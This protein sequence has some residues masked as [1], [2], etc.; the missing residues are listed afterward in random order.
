MFP[1]GAVLPLWSCAFRFGTTVV[2]ATTK[3]AVPVVIVLVICPLAD[4]VVNAPLPGVVPPIA[5]GAANV[6][7][8]KSAAFRLGTTVVEE[9]V[10]GAVPVETV[11]VKLGALIAFGHK[12]TSLPFLDRHKSALLAALRQH[13][14]LSPD[15]RRSRPLCAGFALVD[16]KKFADRL[17]PLRFNVPSNLTCRLPP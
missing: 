15:A 17:P 3:G 10:K 14:P 11:L 7:P 9:T 16:E 6:A 1:V 4:M 2:L 12:S 13:P 8:F 5:P